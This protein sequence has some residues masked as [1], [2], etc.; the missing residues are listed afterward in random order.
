MKNMALNMEICCEEGRQ[1]V[2]IGT[3]NGT[4][5]EYPVECE[6]DIGKAV[7]KYVAEYYPEA[8][9]AADSQATKEMTDSGRTPVHAVVSWYSFDRPQV[10]LFETDAEAEA[11]LRETARQELKTD[12]EENGWTASLSID[13]DGG[14]AKLVTSF[15]GH[16]DTTEFVMP[17]LVVDHRKAKAEKPAGRTT[18]RWDMENL[19]KGDTFYV[20][21]EE[22]V[23][24]CDTHY[25][26]DASYD[27][28]IVYDESGESYFSD[29][30]PE[31]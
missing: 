22:H 13:E 10:D 28:Y 2:W 19:R 16:D 21:G 31:R 20:N 30:F 23:A 27:G 11:Y 3:E 29:E 25:S 7:E 26:G 17:S 24:A 15:E 5:A 6:G 9:K 1:T 14:Y 8:V 18:L 12:T 4:G